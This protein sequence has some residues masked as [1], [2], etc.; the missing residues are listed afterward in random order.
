MLLRKTEAHNVC[1]VISE[2]RRSAV[3]IVFSETKCVLHA[4]RRDRERHTHTQFLSSLLRCIGRRTS[5]MHFFPITTNKNIFISHVIRLV[6]CLNVHRRDKASMRE[7]QF[8]SNSVCVFFCVCQGNGK[9]SRY[10]TLLHSKRSVRMRDMN[11]WM[12]V[13]VCLCAYLLACLFVCV[14]FLYKSSD[15][16][17]KSNGMFGLQSDVR[18]IEWKFK[19]CVGR[20][21]GEARWTL[22]FFTMWT[23][24]RNHIYFSRTRE[25]PETEWKKTSSL[26]NRRFTACTLHLRSFLLTLSS[27]TTLWEYFIHSPGNAIGDDENWIRKNASATRRAIR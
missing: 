27:L 1:R 15:E 2:C 3:D 17:R 8:N 13:C 9:Y 7:I 11:L 10:W 21:W 22:K 12:C 5:S 26:V 23:L 16:H 19:D 14:Y 24:A 18:K 20:L 6:N 4:C 25:R